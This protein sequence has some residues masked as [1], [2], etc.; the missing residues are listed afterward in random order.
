MRCNR[1]WRRSTGERSPL[2]IAAAA[3]LAVRRC[4][5]DALTGDWTTR[6]LLSVLIGLREVVL[7]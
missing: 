5:E 7:Q 1:D 6:H 3:S 2:A 4:M